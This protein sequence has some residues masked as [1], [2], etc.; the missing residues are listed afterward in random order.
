MISFAEIDKVH[1]GEYIKLLTLVSRLSSLFSES[2]VPFI[3]YRVAEN[4]F[5][6]SFNADNLSRSD[7][8][9]DAKYI[10]NKISYGVGLKTFICNSNNS[11]EKISEFNSYSHELKALK[12]EELAFRLSEL[13]NLRI[14]AA[15]SRYNVAKSIYHVVARRKKKI[16]LF[17]TDYDLI[18]TKKIKVIH[19]D[20]KTLKF[21]DRSNEYSFNFSKS[22]LY[23]KFTIP[24]NYYSFEV[25]ILDDPFSVLYELGKINPNKLL[26]NPLVA[27]INYVILPLYSYDR[28]KQKFVFEK[29]GLNQWNAGGRKRDYGELYI[30][31][32]QVIHSVFPN[33]FPNKE[34]VFKLRVPGDESPLTAK[35][36]QENS[37]ALMTNPN[38]SLSEWLLRS[39]L[40]LKEGEL[41]TIE[42]LNMLGFDS[43]IVTKNNEL[44][45]SIDVCKTD[46]YENF[47]RLFI[48]R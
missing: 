35:L 9:F 16:I 13:R 28:A 47:Y 40:L 30:P 48:K 42:R 34:I 5:C 20:S 21:N 19:S 43:V 36:C 2:D 14:I 32:P 10:F 18:E 46:S 24:D 45:Y 6:R 1:Q 37:K 3:N 29:S 11:L 15:K 25:Q 12:G 38:K 44:D 4:I 7:T 39:V 41:A 23:R 17:E 8:A 27:G 31:I 22:T 33:F 26:T